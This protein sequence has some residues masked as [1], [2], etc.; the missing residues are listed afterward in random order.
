MTY[1]MTYYMTYYDPRTTLTTRIII[2]HGLVQFPGAVGGP[3]DHHA[4]TSTT[5]PVK[6][7]EEF[8]LE[9]PCSIMLGLTAFRQDRVNLVC[10]HVC[11]TYDEGDIDI[12]ADIINLP[13]KMMEGCI[14]SAMRKSMRTSFSASP[15]HLLVSDDA[16][17][18]KN[19]ALAS[20]ASACTC[21]CHN[22]STR[23]IHTLASMVLPLPG[24][25]YSNSPRA[26]ARSP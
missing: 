21:L 25:P 18:A 20:C 7:H 16:E 6:L 24:G 5:D 15:C 26:G 14:C 9:A 3:D 1:D 11:S 19:V 2:P 12:V 8:S 4:V 23:S 17:M 10:R 13:I 22:K